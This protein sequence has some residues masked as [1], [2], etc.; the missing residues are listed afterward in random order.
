MLLAQAERRLGIAERLVR[1]EMV[2]RGARSNYANSDNTLTPRDKLTNDHRSGRVR[3]L[4][5]LIALLLLSLGV[6]AV[7]W[8]AFFSLRQAF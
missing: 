1:E 7:I 4:A 3:R 6:W 8:I 5:K 2:G